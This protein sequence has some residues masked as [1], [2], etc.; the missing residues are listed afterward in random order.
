[1]ASPVSIELSVNAPVL[2]GKHEDLLRL[3]GYLHLEHGSPEKAVVIFDALLALLPDDTQLRYSLVYALLRT[4]NAE[5]AMQVIE[6]SSG[7]LR[8]GDT[9]A[10]LPPLFHLLR[11]Q[12]LVQLGRLPEAAR[13]MRI[14]IRHRRIE[15]AAGL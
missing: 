7:A 9:A 11:S 12:A 6:A 1:M 14:F 15:Q 2:S 8:A 10:Q 4:A 3:I 5:A 13:S